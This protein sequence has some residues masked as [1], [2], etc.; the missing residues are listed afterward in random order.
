MGGWASASRVSM[1]VAIAIGSG[2]A[3]AADPPPIRVSVPACSSTPFSVEAFLGSLAVELAGHVPACCLL[4]QA[5]S[6]TVGDSPAGLRVTLSIEPCDSSAT[7]VD[8]R[9]HDAAHATDSERRVGLG[10]IPIEARPGGWPWRSRSWCTP[11]QPHRWR[12]RA[13]RPSRP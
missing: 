13:R 11:R 5:A 6:P 10:D 1:A 8:V 12:R 9:V 7:S 2:N 3:A 4:E